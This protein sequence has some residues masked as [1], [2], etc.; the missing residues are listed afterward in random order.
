MD[1]DTLQLL[2]P[3]NMKK[4]VRDAYNARLQMLQ[5]AAVPQPPVAPVAMPQP[6][7]VSPSTMPLGASSFMRQRYP[8]RPGLRRDDE[9]PPTGY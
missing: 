1:V 6:G 2:D 7:V 4:P 5:Q 8:S 9:L 3:E